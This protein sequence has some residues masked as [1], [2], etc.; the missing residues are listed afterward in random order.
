[1]LSTLFVDVLEDTTGYP[2]LLLALAECFG[3]L[4]RLFDFFWRQKIF[5]FYKMVV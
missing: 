3:L 5:F 1:M 4:P 2:G